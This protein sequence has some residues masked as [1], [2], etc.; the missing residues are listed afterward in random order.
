MKLK[1]KTIIALISTAILGLIVIQVIWINNA[2]ALKES[3]FD[4]DVRNSLVEVIKKVPK[5]EASNQEKAFY[6]RQA[7]LKNGTN[8]P[9]AFIQSMFANTPFEKTKN[10]ISANQLD[11]LIKIEL[12]KKGINTFYVFGVFDT[13]GNTHYFKDSA[14]EK[15]SSTLKNEGINIQ[16]FTNDFFTSKVF[17]SVFFPK[18]NS[19]IFK[20]MW[21]ILSVSFLLILTVIYAFYF[22]VNTIQKQKKLSEMKNDFINN[23]THEFKTPISTIQLACEALSDKDMQSTES[24]IPFIDIIKQENKR[25]KGLVDTVLKTAILDKGKVKLELET[26]N[27]LEVMYSVVSKF[28]LKIKQR[29]GSIKIENEIS[30]MEFKG[31]RQHL[32]AVFQNIIDNAIKYS[33]ENPTIIISCFHNTENYIFKIKDNGIG[34]SKENQSKIFDK[35]YRVPTGDLHDVKGFGLGLNYVKSIIEL[36]NGEIAVES[37]K[38]KGSTFTIQLPKNT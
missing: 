14:S 18:K 3:Q 17:L 31:D 6:K 23:M 33:Q 12:R 15:M 8:N 38:T 2:I 10:R 20:R 21:V 5:I 26:L 27:L 19:Y 28:E 7:E 22:T 13:E 25:L 1:I 37:T 34:I 11:S 9:N 16:L 24:K 32:V 30:E 4:E 36:H 29:K 35:L